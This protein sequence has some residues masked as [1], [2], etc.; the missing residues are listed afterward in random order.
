[1]DIRVGVDPSPVG[2]LLTLVVALSLG[3]G[4]VD[5]FLFSSF[6]PFVLKDVDEDEGEVGAPADW[7]LRTPELE[8]LEPPPLEQLATEEL[9]PPLAE[10]MLEGGGPAAF[11]GE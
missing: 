5:F 9:R 1:M 7:G 6:S 10:L 3:P 8:L 2:A 4:E 11:R